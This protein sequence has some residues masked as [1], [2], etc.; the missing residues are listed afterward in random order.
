MTLK[1]PVKVMK[2]RGSGGV[3]QRMRSFHK[4]MSLAL[5]LAALE[6]AQ[7][8][9]APVQPPLLSLASSLRMLGLGG[10]Q[11]GSRGLCV[12]VVTRSSGEE[13]ARKETDVSSPLA[14]PPP[15]PRQGSNGGSQ[16]QL[17]L[18]E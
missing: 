5:D 12:E 1:S 7:A 9:G 13:G 14:S 6:Q 8:D 17:M 11:Q 16:T 4:R 10:Q 2:V 3:T 15:A 18:L